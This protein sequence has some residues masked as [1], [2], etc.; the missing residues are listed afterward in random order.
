M[1][2]TSILLIIHFINK[3]TIIILNVRKEIEEAKEKLTEKDKSLTNL[4]KYFGAIRLK[5]EGH[6]IKV[7]CYGTSVSAARKII[8]AQ[9]DVKSWF[10]HIASNK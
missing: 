6:P 9:F 3:K 7:Y 8:E 4:K 1:S 10:R 5:S 2:K